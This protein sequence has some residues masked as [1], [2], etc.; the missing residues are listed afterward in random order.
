MPRP[1]CSRNKT[2]EDVTI[3]DEVSM[4]VLKKEKLRELGYSTIT[5]IATARADEIQ[6]MMKVTFAIAKGWTA[7]AQEKLSKTMVFQTAEEQ[8]KEKKGK[9]LFF[10]TGAS[11]LNKLIGGGVPTMSIT[12]LSGRLSSGKTQICFDAIIDCLSKG[13]KAVFIETE[14]DFFELDRLKERANARIIRC[15]WSKVYVQGAER[16][17]TP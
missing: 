2:S 6:A 1:K 9:Q 4:E 12:G 7:Q 10:L 5:D 11:D 3:M 8:D 14:P 15:N 16:S 13:Y 17:P